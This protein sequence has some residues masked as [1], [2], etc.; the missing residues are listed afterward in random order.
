ME[1]GSSEIFNENS[2]RSRNAGVW[3]HGIEVIT[4]GPQFLYKQKNKMAIKLITCG[5]VAF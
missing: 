4:V 2:E 5:A 3:R 1:S